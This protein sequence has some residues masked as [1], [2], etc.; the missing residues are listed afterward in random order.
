MTG[1]LLT[2]EKVHDIPSFQQL[3][4]VFFQRFQ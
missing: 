4:V 1:T 2:K 3:G